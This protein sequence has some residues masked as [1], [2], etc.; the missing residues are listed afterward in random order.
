MINELVAEFW[1]NGKDLKEEDKFQAALNRLLKELRKNLADSNQLAM[2]IDRKDPS[3]IMAKIAVEVNQIDLAE[4][5][6]LDAEKIEI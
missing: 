6:L 5:L 4:I 3:E 2:S 1:L